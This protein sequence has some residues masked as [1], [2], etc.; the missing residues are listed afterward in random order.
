MESP[1]PR[2]EWK[3]LA[4]QLFVLP[5]GIVAACVGIFLL[6]GSLANDEKDARALVS[7]IRKSASSWPWDSNARWHAAW[8]LPSAVEKDRKALKA[9]PAFAQS[10]TE[11]LADPAFPDEVR[12]SMAHALGVL[13][14]PGA[15]PALLRGLSAGGEEWA[16]TRFACAQSLGSLKSP[17]AVEPLKTLLQDPVP[18]VREMAAT[19]LGA[20]GTPEAEKALLPALG[21]SDREVRWHVA[22]WLARRG[23]RASVP[24]LATLLDPKTFEKIAPDKRSLVMANAAKSAGALK[25][26]ELRAALEAL[27]KAPEA[28]VRLAAEEAL[29]AYRP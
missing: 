28:P 8:M 5:A 13:D 23:N 7:E 9:D 6:F 10:L 3:V 29:I 12:S 21:N 1:A 27:R 18:T 19:A 25:A 22:I 17:E 4:L 24:V 14:D 2:V 15:A 20:I 26:P 11:I 16:R